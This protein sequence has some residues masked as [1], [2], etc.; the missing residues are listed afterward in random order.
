MPRFC[1]TPPLE[2]SAG[3][4]EIVDDDFRLN[5]CSYE[6]EILLTAAQ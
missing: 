3:G 1:V 4:C 6:A 5:N 2:I